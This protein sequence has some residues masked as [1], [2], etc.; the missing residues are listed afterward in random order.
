MRNLTTADD[1]YPVGSPPARRG[2]SRVE[3]RA[4]DKAAL[5]GVGL[6]AWSRGEWQLV[7]ATTGLIQKRGWVDE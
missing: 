6:Y 2:W 3:V 5:V 7:V 4:H 1:G